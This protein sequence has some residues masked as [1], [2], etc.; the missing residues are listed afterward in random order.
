MPDRRGCT[1]CGAGEGLKKNRQPMQLRDVAA[2]LRKQDDVNGV[3]AALKLVD[4]L[5]EAVPDELGQ[6]A[7]VMSRPS[8]LINL[9]ETLAHGQRG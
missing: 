3:L 2:A 5:I 1:S 7:G 9:N 8:R 4:G 6:Y